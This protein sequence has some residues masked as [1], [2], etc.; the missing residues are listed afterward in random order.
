[1]K[2]TQIMNEGE[3]KRPLSNEVKKHFLEIVSTYNKYQESL[4]RK[5][6][7]QEIAETLG[8]ITEAARTLAIHEGDDWFDKHTVK[9]NMSELDKLGQQF[10]KCA[11]EANSLDQR[12]GGLYED[13][14]HILSRY[15]KMGEITEDQMKERLGMNE[16]VGCGCGGTTES[17][18][19]C[20]T[21]THESVINEEPV[22]VSMRNPNG[23]ITTT[24][25]E[26]DVNEAGDLQFVCFIDT[27]R[28]K[29]LLKVFKSQRAANMFLK[30]SVDTIL[31][32]TGVESI[33]TM[34][35]KEWNNK[36]AKYAIESVVNESVVNEIQYD[37][38]LAK[39]N[40][41]LEN[42]SEIKKAAKHYKKSVKDI[43]KV[44]QSRIKVNRYSD[45]SIKQISINFTEDGPLSSKVTIKSS[46]NH[47]QNESINES[48]S[49]EAMGIAGFTGTRGSAVQNFIDDYSLNSKK[50]FK[51]ISKADLKKRLE[52]VNAIAG[53][54]GNKN[55]GKIVGMFGESVPQGYN[56]TVE[57]ELT[58]LGEVVEK[59]MEK[60]VPTNPSKWSYY[61]AQAKKKFDVYPS[62]YA[63][64]W[65]A[66]QYKAA[67]G[68]WKNES[69]N[70]ANVDL[71]NIQMIN[72]IIKEAK[73]IY[74]RG[75]KFVKNRENITKEAQRLN[76][77]SSSLMEGG[78][79]IIKEF[80]VNA[81][82]LGISPKNIKEYQKAIDWL[83]V[84]YTIQK[85]SAGYT[86]LRKESV[87]EGKSFVV[88][89]KVKK[90][91]NNRNVKPSTAA[92]SS[93]ADAKKFLQSVE[94]DGGNGMVTHSNVKG[95]KE[96]KFGYKD[97]TSSYI[98]KHKDE[99]KVAEKLNK[100]NEV[101]FYDSL[102]Q[103]EEK[104]GHP[105]FMIFLSNALRGY[106]VDMYKD[107]K[108]KNPQDA[109]EALFLLSK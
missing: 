68:G 99:Y 88:M 107:P 38:A 40:K 20:G 79:K 76:R 97:S 33:G 18:C 90:D 52:F 4:D 49:K 17:S 47:K 13:M 31:S 87:N 66:K 22:T 58:K 53:T 73:K 16:S 91:I 102:S 50:L 51:Y 21:H 104:I 94:K 46:Q 56:P 24:L 1:M 98:N 85:Q 39:F 6:D 41:E 83:G 62:A 57:T 92:Y 75:L 34:S 29:K 44:L 108:I 25:K 43:V 55:Q 72:R 65:A 93:E 100:G 84:L 82:E 103:M 45:K 5:S 70:E 10:D 77:D 59:L 15:Y 48:V 3:E 11:S 54:R 23:S 36:E 105:K 12:L 14:G 60:N 69:V 64:G 63:N 32:K 37:D 96:A 67:G 106:K 86:K 109:Q 2:L 26:D 81:K 61:K 7:I 28:G 42:N 80:E 101:K 89:F 8:G 35:E 9:R 27:T 74:N 78:E 95:M 71:V 30:K 19:G